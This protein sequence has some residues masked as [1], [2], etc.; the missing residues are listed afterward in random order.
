MGEAKSEDLDRGRLSVR[1]EN[2]A[3]QCDKGH[4][5]VRCNGSYGGHVCDG[6]LGTEF[7]ID[8]RL[9]KSIVGYDELAIG[10][11]RTQNALAD[12]KDA[13]QSPDGNFLTFLRA[14]DLAVYRLADGKIGDVVVR[15][16][17]HENDYAVMAQWSLCDNVARWD[18]H[19]GVKF[20]ITAALIR[21]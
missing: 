5:V 20:R 12:A 7:D 11:D 17:L 18:P 6:Y 1:P 19:I 3:I 13:F 10:F 15:Q 16:P 4:W 9:P 2:W 14:S 21:H 8:M